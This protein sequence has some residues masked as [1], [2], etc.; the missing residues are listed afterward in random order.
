MKKLLALLV[1][2]SFALV[3][4]ANAWGCRKRCETAVSACPEEVREAPEPVCEVT[5]TYKE[6]VCPQKFVDISY[7]CP[8]GSETSDGGT[9]VRSGKK[10]RNK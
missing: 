1:I 8:P 6:R 9:I 7:A 10:M 3:Q 2:S 5:K 4:D